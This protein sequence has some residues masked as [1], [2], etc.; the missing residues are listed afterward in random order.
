MGSRVGEKITSGQMQTLRR[1][2]KNNS[3]VKKKTP[4]RTLQSRTPHHVVVAGKK[5]GGAQKYSGGG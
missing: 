4:A 1:G 2:R 3:V 5:Y